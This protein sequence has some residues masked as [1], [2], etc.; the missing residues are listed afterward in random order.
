[1]EAEAIKQAL[2]AKGFTFAMIGEVLRVNANVVSAVCYRRTTSH[3]VAQAVAKALE[4]P[5]HDVFPDVPSYA[6]P[7]LPR[8]AERIAKAAELQQLLAS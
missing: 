4:K 3:A 8:G 5:I 6:K 2:R 7:S 1:M